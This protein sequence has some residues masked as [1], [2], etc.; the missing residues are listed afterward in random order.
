[1]LPY[2][3][4]NAYGVWQRFCWLYPELSRFKCPTIEFNNRL[5]TCAG[6]CFVELNKIDIST[7]LYMEFTDEFQK[8][9]IPH[10]I[11]HQIDFNLFGNAGHGKTWKS[12]MLRYGIPAD[13][14]HTLFQIREERLKNK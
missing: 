8:I 14:Y 11:A 10:E 12:V 1:M 4:C 13:T 2:L 5:K 3:E 9:I 7:S 6:R